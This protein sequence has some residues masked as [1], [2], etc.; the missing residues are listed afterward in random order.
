MIDGAIQPP[1]K[2]IRTWRTFY[3]MDATLLEILWY[4][5][6]SRSCS[7]V[8]SYLRTRHGPT[9]FVG[10]AHGNIFAMDCSTRRMGFCPRFHQYHGSIA[11]VCLWCNESASDRAESHPDLVFNCMPRWPHRGSG[12]CS[13][14]IPTHHGY[15]TIRASDDDGETLLTDCQG[16][17]IHPDN[18]S[19]GA[20]ILGQL[21]KRAILCLP[22]C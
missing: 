9:P 6:H 2:A 22:P 16:L 5:L 12:H 15:T 10:W 18:R 14:S 13:P 20:C 19:R 7:Y 21:K 17:E 11:H 3:P 1:S 8:L 4:S